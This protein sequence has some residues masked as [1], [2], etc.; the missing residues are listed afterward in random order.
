M[1]KSLLR[2][3]SS[4]IVLVIGLVIAG[5]FAVAIGQRTGQL[6]QIHKERDQIERQ[7]ASL[8][9]RHL[10]LVTTRDRLRDGQDVEKL[11]RENLN[12]V[13]PGEIAVIVIP[14]SASQKPTEDISSPPA[15]AS[16]GLQRWIE[17]LFRS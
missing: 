9:D 16:N 17:A 12:L 5:Y 3:P 13:K 8:E 1:I 14:S 15:P 4:A 2:S 6:V 10:D 11:A 7:I